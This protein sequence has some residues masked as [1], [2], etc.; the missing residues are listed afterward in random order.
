LLNDIPL[1]HVRK[2]HTLSMRASVSVNNDALSTISAADTK[3][4]ADFHTVSEKGGTGSQTLNYDVSTS[5]NIDKLFPSRWGV[6]LPVSYSY[7]NNYSHSKF[8]GSTDILVNEKNIPD[9]VKTKQISEAF[10]YSIKKSSKSDDPLLKYTIDNLSYSGTSN[11]IEGSNPESKHTE[12]ETFSNNISYGL[13]LPVGWFSLPIFGWTKDIEYLRHLA[14]ENF[15]FFPNNYSVSLST[16]QGR[17]QSVSRKNTVTQNTNFTV[18]RTF[19][20][21]LAPFSILKSDYT[22]ALNS[23]MYKQRRNLLDTTLV[24]SENP[25]VVGNSGYVNT[26][27]PVNPVIF[28]HRPGMRGYDRL[29]MFDFGELDTWK[30]S[31]NTSLQFDLTKWTAY[32]FSH[33]T[34]YNWNANL[35]TPLNGRSLSN[36][37]SISANTRLKSK[38][39][40]QSL[41]ATYN[42]WFPAKTAFT[43]SISDSVNTVPDQPEIGDDKITHTGRGGRSDDNKT[44]KKNINFNLLNYF[45]E[46]LNDINLTMN[47]NRSASII[48]GYDFDQANLEFQLGFSRIPQNYTEGSMTWSGG[49]D[50]KLSTGLNIMK[51]VSLSNLSYTFKRSYSDNN[52]DL[53]GSDSKTQFIIP[54]FLL[55]DEEDQVKTNIYDN[56]SLPLPDYSISYSGLKDLFKVDHIFSS[57]DLSHSKAGSRSEVWYLK[58][59]RAY[60]LNGLNIPQFSTEDSS[61]FIVKSKKYNITFAPVL[62]LKMAFKNQMNIDASFDYSFDIDEGYLNRKASSG[63]KKEAQ[64]YKVSAGYSQKG[65]FQTPF[66]FWPFSG[67]KMDNDIVYSFGAS[68]GI[69]RNYT[70]KLNQ[71]VYAYEPKNEGAE[72]IITSLS[73]KISYKLAKNIDGSF[74][75]SYSRRESKSAFDAPVE[76]SADHIMDLTFTMKIVSK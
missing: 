24:E 59:T 13:N 64:T 2:K 30:S 19:N 51:D 25:G 52:V 67:K 22:L 61:L 48:N 11:F 56:F 45:K 74:S 23:D 68:Y 34:S 42:A 8:E 71:G 28:T 55:T 10:T 26:E 29:F 3:K 57:L 76:I 38:E 63:S 20:T 32:S 73:P 40:F 27:H 12:S 39:V 58:N 33:N 46:S 14:N 49:Y 50:W 17:N 60:S 75:Y 21:S 15:N 53:N 47:T 41:D 6:T 1:K 54:P 18:A 65:G 9:S 31:F 36:S 37:Y 5:A 70:A 7:A 62:G 4:D 72:T 43:E 69:T 16:N 35:M 66:N 44:P